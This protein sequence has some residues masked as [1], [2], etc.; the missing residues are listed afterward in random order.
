MGV[1]ATETENINDTK[2]L[3]LRGTV[4][5]LFCCMPAQLPCP[6]DIA[7]AMTRSRSTRSIVSGSNSMDH[8]TP[9]NGVYF[10]LQIPRNNVTK[11]DSCVGLLIF[12]WPRALS[13]AGSI[14]VEG[15]LQRVQANMSTTTRTN[16]HDFNNTTCF[17]LGRVG[18]HRKFGGHGE[19]IAFKHSGHPFR[20]PLNGIY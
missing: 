2:A 13:F 17:T 14:R 4:W 8:R 19:G 16:T 20:I 1:V 3:S 18:F 10:L 6:L 5:T 12:C 15:V 7:H 11:C 9:L